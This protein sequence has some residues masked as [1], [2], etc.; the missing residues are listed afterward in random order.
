MLQTV[1]RTRPGE[2]FVQF[3]RT[4]RGK[5][6]DMFLVKHF[7]W[8]LLMTIFA[9]KVGYP[10]MPILIVHTIGRRSGKEHSAVMPYV[11][12]EGVGY[13]FGAYGGREQDPHWVENIRAHPEVRITVKR[14]TRRVKARELSPG[15]DEYTAVWAHALTRT[16]E[17]DK[18]QQ[19]M[20]RKTPV[21]ALG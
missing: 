5:R 12:F 3:M 11:P 16:P 7:G 13:L 1:I 10:P 6:L 8:S 4:P 15:S 21:I 18:Y 17:Y 9:A 20:K 2:R 14:K 19:K